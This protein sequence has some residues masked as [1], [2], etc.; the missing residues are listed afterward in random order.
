[1]FDEGTHQSRKTRQRR[2]HRLCVC[3]ATGGVQETLVVRVRSICD[4]LGRSHKVLL[5]TDDLTATM[6]DVDKLVYV[7]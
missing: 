2:W 6:Q 3:F 4:P 1:M 7:I 5:W